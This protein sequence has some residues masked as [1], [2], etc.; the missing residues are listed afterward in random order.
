[1]K[2]LTIKKLSFYSWHARLSS[3]EGKVTPQTS[4]KTC[5][6]FISPISA[7]FSLNNAGSGNEG[8]S[9]YSIQSVLVVCFER[10]TVLNFAVILYNTYSVV[11]KHDYQLVLC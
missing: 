11:L 6:P 2:S 4:Q 7:I 9:N 5:F 1:M 8:L 3:P 10:L